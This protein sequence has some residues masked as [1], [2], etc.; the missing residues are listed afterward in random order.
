MLKSQ[1]LRSLPLSAASGLVVL[2]RYF[3]VVADDDLHLYVL[4]VK[5]RWQVQEKFGLIRVR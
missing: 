4:A 5:I 2:E 3:F 1:V